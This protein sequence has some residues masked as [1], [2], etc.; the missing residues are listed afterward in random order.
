MSK[1]NVNDVLDK[2]IKTLGLSEMGIEHLYPQI[3]DNIRRHTLPEFSQ[4]FPYHYMFSLHLDQQYGKQLVN[5]AK[6]FLIT[7]PFLDYYNP[8]ILGIADLDETSVFSSYNALSPPIVDPEELILNAAVTNIRSLSNVSYKG[9]DFVP[10]KHV[11]LHGYDGRD[12]VRMTLKLP[13]PGFSTIKESTSIVFHQWC[14]YD[15]KIF[16][17]GVFKLY[18]G[19]ETMDGSIDLKMA[20]WEGAESEKNDWIDDIRNRA[21]PNQAGYRQRYE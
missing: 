19:L 10:P 4:F 20:D 1:L 9:H 14:M 12:Q 8:K 6:E 18:D 16:L 7:D 21:F 5:D 15:T 17:Y 11:R 13:H 3:I 2:I